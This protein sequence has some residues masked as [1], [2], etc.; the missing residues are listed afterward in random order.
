MRTIVH[1]QVY[2]YVCT[3]VHYDCLVI[4]AHFDEWESFLWTL[5]R[6]TPAL[7][8]ST[9]KGWPNK[10]NDWKLQSHNALT[11][12]YRCWNVPYWPILH[13]NIHKPSPT[14]IFVVNYIFILHV[15]IFIQKK[16]ETVMILQS[17][18]KGLRLSTFLT[19]IFQ[20]NK[21]GHGT[22]FHLEQ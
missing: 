10:K 21:Y 8:K 4:K 17:S 6:L 11:R 5:Q 19:Y 20:K 13:Q 1:M 15:C 18:F 16:R 9:I 14:I 22:D 3:R 12:T 2:R 7:L